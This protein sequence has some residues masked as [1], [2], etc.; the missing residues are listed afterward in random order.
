[1]R[2]RDLSVF[3]LLVLL[4]AICLSCGPTAEAQLPGSISGMVTD[5]EGQPLEGCQVYA[6]P[7]DGDPSGPE[8]TNADGSYTVSN[9]TADDYYVGVSCDGYVSEYYEG[10]RW[11]NDATL[12]PVAEGEDTPDIDFSLD[13]GGSISGVATDNQGGPIEGCTIRAIPERVG[14]GTYSVTTTNADGSYSIVSLTADDYGLAI[15][16]DDYL[17]EYYNAVSWLDDATV[18]SVV[19]GQDTPNINFTLD[20]GGT[21]SGGVRDAQGNPLEGCLVGADPWDDARTSG[22]ASTNPD[23]SYTISAL[24]PDEDYQV[25]AGCPG[26]I[27]EFSSGVRGYDGAVRVHVVEGQDTPNINFNLDSAGSISGTVTDALENPLED[28]WVYVT[29]WDDSGTYGSAETDLVGFYTIDGL[30]TGDYRV[31]VDCEGHVSTY[32]DGVREPDDATPVSVVE[33]EATPNID[34]SLGPLG[35][36]SGVVTDSGETPLNDC[37]VFAEPAEGDPTSGRTGYSDTDGSYTVTSLAAG[38]YW[39]DVECDGYVHDYC[40]NPDPWSGT[41]VTVVDGQDTPNINFSCLDLGGSI[42]GVVTDAQ[43][44]PIDG[45]TVWVWGS[46]DRPDNAVLTQ[47]DGSYIVTTL[48]PSSYYAVWVLKDGYAAE[49]YNGA[50]W[51]QNATPVEV[52]L[53]QNTPHVDFTLDA[54]GGISGVIT[55]EQGSPIAAAQIRVEPYDDWYSSLWWGV[56]SGGW[57]RDTSRTDGSYHVDNLGTGGYLVR[58]EAEC[59]F[60]EYYP[61]VSSRDDAQAVSVTEPEYTNDVGFSLVRDNDCDMV[62]VSEDNCPTVYN[63]DQLDSD[64]DGVGDACESAPVGGVAEAPDSAEST[65]V[66]WVLITVLAG[67]LMVGVLA[68]GGWAYSSRRR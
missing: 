64:G 43:S 58:A 19:E 56:I 13:A 4:A 30:G 65:G 61:G 37:R 8:P 51:I 45:A 34:F 26:Y 59:C 17:S 18:V 11:A 35:T 54:G 46:S 21:I 12:V 52:T 33:G 41:A 44:N 68:C 31:N 47:P 63:P 6:G 32:F 29:P 7:S 16:C 53:S 67:V 28:C 15:E 57:A 60:S 1:M 36:I 39:L 9:L 22:N 24:A 66:P 27:T 42:S 5:T 3:P 62:P 55:D 50:R 48:P 10:V 38:D 23:G 25:A 14:F 49:Y 2:S 40:E 20:A